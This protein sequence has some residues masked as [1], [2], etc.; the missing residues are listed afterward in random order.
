MTMFRLAS[1]APN[2]HLTLQAV[3]LRWLFG[4]LAVSYWVQAEAPNRTRLLAKLCVRYPR[5]P[6]GWLMRLILP[7]GDWVMMR[8]QLLNFKNLAE[9]TRA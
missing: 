3:L 6:L 8:R 2:E 9:N 4:E 1:F 5:G 7:W